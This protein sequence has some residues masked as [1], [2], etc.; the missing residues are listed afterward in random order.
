MNHA[1]IALSCC[2]GF[3]CIYSWN[4]QNLVGNFILYG[5]EPAQV[6]AYS[7]FV[8]RGTWSDDDKKF[9]GFSS[10]DIPDFLVAFF[11]RV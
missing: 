6:I 1:F 4:D 8:V 5:A 7:V 11:F 9:I 2:S 10:K 3:I